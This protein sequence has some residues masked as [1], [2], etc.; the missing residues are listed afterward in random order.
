MSRSKLIPALLLGLLLLAAGAF[1]ALLFV[2]PA[3]FR[4][5]LEARATEAFGREVRLAG[6]I[7]LERSLKPRLVA[8]E[9]TI[10]NPEW[11]V[12]PA[13]A[14]AEEIAVQVALLPLLRGDLRVLDIRFSGVEI[15]LES[16]PDGAA[17]HAFGDSGAADSGAE[18]LPPIERILIR[19]ASLSHRSL[20]GVVTRYKI[21]QAQLWNLPGEPER[22]EAEGSIKDLPFRIHLAADT[23]AEATGPHL[24]W[25]ARLEL[26]CPD[27]LLT[28]SG[29]VARVFDWEHF[30]LRIV[31][32]GD[33][34]DSIQNIF[35]IDL[36]GIHIDVRIRHI[37]GGR[38]VRAV[39]PR[40][41]G[42][43]QRRT[44]RRAERQRRR[45]R[46]RHRLAEHHG[47]R[48]LARA[49]VCIGQQQ[50]ARR[51]IAHGRVLRVDCHGVRAR[52][53]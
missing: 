53:A 37:V 42:H 19:N 13:F 5:Q 39:R 43:R 29:R 24:P 30:D 14:T 21:H 38:V 23:P 7:R 50:V 48:Q 2:D 49:H 8:R 45:R 52:R 16:R 32:R 36:H 17:P 25:S 31:A 41:A 15:F 3:L 6:P 12:D 47:H 33:R 4:S 9:I 26:Q 51:H 27:L 34:P 18:A 22:I 28:A 11:A 46:G 20:K 40:P 44:H 1:A 10:A 35:D